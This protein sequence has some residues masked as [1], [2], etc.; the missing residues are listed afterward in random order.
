MRTTTIAFSLLAAAALAAGAVV[1]A[2]DGDGDLSP[3]DQKAAKAAEDEALKLGEKVFND[4]A[5]GTSDRACATCH[6]NPKKPELNLKGI[7][8]KFPRWDRQAGKVITMQE[9]FV[10]MQQRSLKAARTLP[11]GDPRWTSLEMYLRGLK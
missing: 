7:T 5:M 1:L 10:Q 4:K 2:Q 8:A 9:K 6:N 11:L 3:E